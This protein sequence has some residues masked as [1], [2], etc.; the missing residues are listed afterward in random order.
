MKT[1]PGI[2]VRQHRTDPRQN[3][4]A[5]KAVRR[6]EEG[7][8]TILL[9][10]CMDEKGRA[11]S[12]EFCVVCE[13]FKTSYRTGKHLMNGDLEN[14]SVGP[15]IPLGSMIEYHPIS[16]EGESRFHQFGRKVLPGIFLGLAL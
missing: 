9:E 7:T 8:S 3:G 10:S 13:T 15:V 2:I 5:E 6:I 11:D 14:Q 16:A 4:I 12:T 1:Y